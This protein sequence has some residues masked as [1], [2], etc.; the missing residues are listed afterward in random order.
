MRI[1][2]IG[3]E[4]AGMSAAAKAKRM[5]KD[6][7]VVVYEMSDIVSF[8][9]C[10]LPYYVGDF[11]DNSDRMIARTAEKFRESGIEVQTLHQVTSVDAQNKKM[12]VKNLATGDVFEDQYDRLF[13]ATGAS[14]IIPPFEGKELENVFTLKT[15]EDGIALKEAAQQEENKNIVVIGAGYIGLEV[16]EA[17]KK[18][19]KEVT[20]IQLTDHI[21]PDSFDSEI[22]EIL[23]E[24][25]RS[26]QVNLK[27]AEMV[28]SLKGEG[29]V[30]A[31]TTDKGE[32]KADI[33]VIATGVRPNTAFLKETGIDMLG[34]GAIKINDRGETSLQDVY[35]A[36]DCASV[37]HLVRKEDVYIPLA[38]T[39]NKIGRIIGENLA[40][41]AS[42]FEGTLG[43]ACLKVMDFEAGRTGIGE[44]EA[45]KM[46]IPYKTVF[47]SDKNQTNYYPGQESIHAKLVYHAE[48]KVILGGQ[49]VGKNGAVLRVDAL[50]V[51]IYSGLTT[52]QLGM[53]DFCYAPPFARTWDVMNVAGNVAK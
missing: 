16:V 28:T 11:Y 27:L 26:H 10:G 13:V 44:K 19:G 12:T 34:N 23:E 36:G 14:A 20:L 35:A 37:Y 33:V 53:M 32:Y 8:G 9:A 4:A 22:A 38:T 46:G 31:V 17:M 39:A 3:G 15:M 7:S 48:T 5:A 49:I 6:A 43:S 47:I 25:I 51:A 41:S 29:K 2:I 52:S 24:E 18:L 45:E 50:A 1:I 40:G 21:L 30:Q 42:T